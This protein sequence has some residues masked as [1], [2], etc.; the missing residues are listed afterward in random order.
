MDEIQLIPRELREAGFPTAHFLS[1]EEQNTYQQSLKEFSG[2]AYDSLNIGRNG[3]SLWKVLWL[4]QIGIKTATLLKLELALENDL[5]LS[6]Y[7]ADSREVIVR[8]NGYSYP[9]NKYLAQKL[10]HDLKLKTWDNP[11]IIKNLKIKQDE[12]SAY[13]LSFIVDNA[14]VIEAP[15]FHHNNH[16]RTFKRINDDYT[17]AWDDANK[18]TFYARDNGLSRVYVGGG[19][20]VG[21]D[22]GRLDI[23]G[24]CGRVVVVGNATGAQK[25]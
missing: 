6:G 16:G 2:K 5:P 10:T 7:Y 24:D 21:S 12:Q 8:S 18:R 23:S 11:Y 20:V 22:D 4:N 19:S 25:N 17:I 3:S 13:G 9:K 14:E 15:D 1:E